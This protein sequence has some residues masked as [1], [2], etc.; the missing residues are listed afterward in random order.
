[1]RCVGSNCHPQAHDDGAGGGGGLVP[2]ATGRW[3]TG[4]G[5]GLG[6]DYGAECRELRQGARS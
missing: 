6:L 5:G 3:G 1:M 2:C 4:D